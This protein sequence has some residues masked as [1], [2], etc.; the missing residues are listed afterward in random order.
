YLGRIDTQVKIRG[1][2][3]E[4]GEIE[5]ALAALPGV[6][7]SL[8]MAREDEPGEK[9]LV[10]YL[11]FAAEHP[12][13]DAA[14]LRTALSRSLPDFMLPAAYV[15]LD[16]FPLTTNGKIDRKAL[17]HP[18][19]SVA[20]LDY[21][22]PRTPIEERLAA[23]WAQVLRLDRISI[24]EGFFTA[25]GDSIRAVSL[26]S[27]ARAQGLEFALVDLFTHQTIANLAQALTLSDISVLPQTFDLSLSEHDSAR[28]PA[29]VED[30]YPL[31]ALQLGMV[32]HNEQA[33]E[34]ASLYHDVFSYR[35]GV[36]AWDETTLRRVLDAMTRRHPVLRT[37]FDLEHFE[38]PLQLVHAEAQVPLTVIDISM[39]DEARQEQLLAEFMEAERRAAVSLDKAPLLRVFIHVRGEQEIQY[40]LSFHH[41]I[42]DGWSVASLNTELFQSYLAVLSGDETSL[43]APPLARTPRSAV[44]AER[45]ALASEAHRGF[46]REFLDGHA[47]SALPAPDAPLEANAVQRA[48]TA[49]LDDSVRARLGSVANSLGVPVRSVLLA[50]HLRVLSMLA[51]KLDVTTGLVSNVRQEQADGEKVLGLFLNTLPLRQTL[52]PMSWAELIRQTFGTELK[53]IRHRHYPYFQLQLENDRQALYEVAF[54]YVNFHVYESLEQAAGFEARGGQGFEATNFAMA[55]SFAD[56]VDGLTIDMKLDPSRLSARQ[57][58]RILAYYMAALTAIA[59]DAQADHSRCDLLPDAERRRLLEEWNRTETPCPFDTPVHLLFEAQAASTP[60]ATAIVDGARSLDYATLDSLATR[61]ARRLASEGVEP[62]ERVAILLDRSIELIVAQLAILK[63]GALYVPLD[64][65]APVERQAFMLADCAAHLVL[66][67]GG[68]ALPEGT[69]AG[70]I[71]IDAVLAQPDDEARPL[72]SHPHPGGDLPAYIMY[73]SGSTGQPK[74]VVVPHRG[75]ARLVLNNGYADFIHSDRIAFTSNPAFDASTMEVWAALLHGA[76]LVVVP[77]DELLA[78]PR[79]AELLRAERVNVLHLVAGLLSSYADALAPV[80]PTLRYLLTGGDAADVRAVQR[81]M[82]NSP[83]QHLIHCYGP[84]ES[85]TF[86]TTYTLRA[87]A[88]PMERLPIGRP[89]SNTRVY[90][91]DAHGQ[92]APT[93]V[94]GE[95]HVGGQ[96]VALGYLNRE[97]LTAERFVRDPFSASPAA[98]LYRTGDLARHLPDGNI[99]YLGRND[100]QVKIRGFRVEPGEIEAKLGEYG[101]RDAIVIARED[102]P[103]EKRLV[104]YHTDVACDVEA[105]RVHLRR[106]LPEYMVPA[107]YVALPQLPLTANGKLDRRALPAPDATAF[108]RRDYE[109]PVGEAET[110]VAAVWAELLGVERVGRHDDFFELGGHSLLAVRVTGRLRHRFGDAASLKALFAAPSLAAFTARIESAAWPATTAGKAGGPAR[111]A[112]FEASAAAARRAAG[113]PFPLSYVQERLWLIQQRDGGRAY[114]MTAVLVLDG[115]LAM[116]SLQ[117]A[118]DALVARHETLRTRFDIAPGSDLPSQFVE[119][120]Y[121]VALPLDELAPA[122][123]LG[124][125]DRHASIEFDL[126][127]GPLLDVRVMRLAP[128]RHV[129]SIVMHHIVSDGWS[130]GVFVQDLRGLYV[131]HRDALAGAPGPFAALPPLAAQYGDYACRQREQDLQ[132]QLAYW[133]SMLEGYGAPVDLSV[134]GTPAEAAHG[135]AGIVRRSLPPALAAQLARL[136]RQHGVSLF[137]VF[138]VALGVL[139][140]RQGGREDICIGTTTAGRDDALLEPM[141]GFFINILPLRLD[142]SGVPDLAALLARAGRLVLDAL[143]HQALPFEHMLAAVPAMRQPDGRSPVPVMLRHQNVPSIQADDWGGGLVLAPLDSIADPEALSRP[144]QSDLDLEIF[145][146]ADGLELVAN[147]DSLRF[148][149]TQIGFMLG[150]LQALLERMV[151]LPGASLAALR[152][153]LPI[154]R[155]LLAGS[156]QTAREFEATSINELFARRVALHPDAPA[157]R[158]EGRTASFAELDRLADRIA[159]ALHRRGIEAGMRIALHAPRSIDFVAAI[160]AS[161]RLGTTYVP[162]DPGYPAAYVRRTL[163]DAM[164]AAIVTSAALAPS[165]AD[166]GLAVLRLDVPEDLET[167]AGALPPAVA[168]R[169]DDL[170][171]IAYTSGSTGQP[172]GVMVEHRQVLN[173]LQ[174]LWA[175]TPFAA[176]EVVGQKTSMSF[177]PSIKE[178]LSGLL[179]GVPQ[180]IFPDALVK[181][182]PAFA[183]ALQQHGVTRLNLVPSH[184]AV[185]LD[186]ADRLG[187]LRHVTTAGEPLSRRLA[188]RFAA[189]LPRARLHNN[190]GCSELNDIT[191]GEDQGLVAQQAVMPAGRPIANCRVHL[192]DAALAPVPVGAVGAIYV[193]GASVG[194]GYWNRPDLTAERFL[195]HPS[196]AWLLRTGD[197]GQ[198]LADGQLLHLGREDFQIKVR[199]QRVELPAVELELGAHPDLAA[200]AAIGR[201]APGDEAGELQLVAFY[202]PARG[203]RPDANTLHAWLSERLPA[204]MVPSRFV[205]LEALPALPNGKLDRLALRAIDPGAA[206]EAGQAYEAPV[207]ELERMLAGIWGE[208]LEVWRVGRHDNFF[209]IGG[210]SLMAAQVAARASEQTGVKL[211]VRSIFDTRTVARLAAWIETARAAPSEFAG[212]QSNDAD[213]GAEFVSFHASGSERPLFLTHTLQGYSWYFEHLAAHIDASIPVVGLPPLAL[214]QP[215][216]DTLDTIAARFVGLMR[217]IQPRGPYR[218][219]GWSFGGLIAYEIAAQLIGQ[220]EEIEFLGVFDTTLPPEGPAIDREQIARVALHSFAIN[221]FSDFDA[222]TIDFEHAGDIAALIETMVQ[223]IEARREAGRPLWHLSYETARENR[224]FLERLVAH[225]RAMSSWRPRRVPVAMHVFAAADAAITPLEGH[226]ALP[227]ALGWEALVERADIELV[228]VP[229]NH[230]TIIKL[231]AD[232]LG[233]AIGAALARRPA[234]HGEERE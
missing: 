60:H 168:T 40:T 190:Y 91:L 61:L 226:A 116:P 92:L 184:L 175:R 122:G 52:A 179:A 162:I 72:P 8:V 71:D 232:K 132:P 44:E 29:D 84:T 15:S 161:F 151:E 37:A 207:G 225:G 129:V 118:F 98:R 141:I 228:S 75:I 105:V 42:L 59:G 195:R 56:T 181:D 163:D 211:S 133:R 115:P 199:G 147:Y 114:N 34:D 125:L 186:H 99:E 13:Q 126:R 26:L 178:M 131:A 45:G 165:F 200:A 77:H 191:Y 64:R 86:A 144:A 48:F 21:V 1:F 94:P 196:G 81:I 2:R 139:H 108:A 5:A 128:Q 41:A 183:A 136:G 202:V 12:A 206:S 135:P 27:K 30:A 142:L 85:T 103:G 101:L 197:I 51:G 24:H 174:A 194:P 121:A 19:Q 234:L 173:C 110:A 111:P 65:N 16:H 17:P 88:E 177:V 109:A 80:F 107:A 210:H 117:A 112:R 66:T 70:R 138:L 223:A 63:C 53:V 69:Q 130:L 198:W 36:P 229:G 93:G 50:A 213:S 104:V 123:L 158:F 182:A 212:R 23:I 9:R 172:K 189:L 127:G 47:F 87:D 32:Y 20:E 231:H 180:V 124:A 89:I 62:G 193:E 152:E 57:G 217:S 220:G 102:V 156:N 187:A 205:A 155:A 76:C 119:A 153:P 230:E 113:R 164:P 167:E 106:S 149:A 192:L 227:E 145:G 148:D 208:A 43:T 143:D 203:A 204:Q 6:R 35:F 95:L 54:N 14:Q 58:E 79:L 46:W 137:T 222:D 4:L 224:L 96:G 55:V 83:P 157:C 140:H 10:A 11:V 90:L 219:A 49:R 201:A 218:V 216:P 22:A 33:S 67:L 176:D 97:A 146:D 215:Q 188:M 7:E 25:G 209:A 39:H 170:A 154:E 100:M 185:L 134:P 18:S 233:R 120:P 171:Y 221:N 73:T 82:R 68:L 31:T 150:T 38:E 28:L 159:G 74:G 160:L 166:T 169:P 214:G 78:A 3:M